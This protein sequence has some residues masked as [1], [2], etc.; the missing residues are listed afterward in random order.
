MDERARRAEPTVSNPAR[1]N[2][3]RSRK[4]IERT[5]GFGIADPPPL[6]RD[7]RRIHFMRGVKLPPNTVS[8]ARPSRWG[9]PFLIGPYT[10]E[11]ALNLYRAH[12]TAK[13]EEDPRFLWPLIG[14]NLACYCP[15]GEAC[16]VD[17]LMEFMGTKTS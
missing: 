5:G 12:L 2:A 3:V 17:I 1:N 11:E 15:P 4:A 13:L 6:V 7:V 8:V 16:H 9:N 10:R 14:K